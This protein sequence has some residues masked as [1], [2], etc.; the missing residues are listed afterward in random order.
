[1]MRYEIMKAFSTTLSKRVLI[2]QTAGFK[3]QMKPS[4]TDLILTNQP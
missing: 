3:N 2:K 1:M 4:L